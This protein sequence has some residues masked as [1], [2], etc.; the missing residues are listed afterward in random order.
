MII[1]ETF[2]GLKPGG[3]KRTRIINRYH[4]TGSSSESGTADKIDGILKFAGGLKFA[5]FFVFKF[6]PTFVAKFDVFLYSGVRGK[7]Y[8][9]RI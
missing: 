4:E 6:A 9:I 7:I 2:I 5:A 3:Q 8:S 1:V